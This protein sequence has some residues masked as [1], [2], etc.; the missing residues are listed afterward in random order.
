MEDETEE[1]AGLLPKC[2]PGFDTVHASFEEIWDARV[3][4]RERDTEDLS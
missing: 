3:G 2:R 1:P 4:E